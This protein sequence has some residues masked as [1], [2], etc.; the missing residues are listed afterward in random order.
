MGI[1]IL[2]IDEAA[3]IPRRSALEL[4]CDGEHADLFPAEASKV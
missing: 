3:P 2:T 4:T 1:R